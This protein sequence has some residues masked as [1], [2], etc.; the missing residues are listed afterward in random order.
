MS[1]VS[2]EAAAA[3][4]KAEEVAA[5]GEKDAT[6]SPKQTVGVKAPEV[7]G[8]AVPAVVVEGKCDPPP[9]AEEKP[10]EVPQPKKA[11]AKKPMGSVGAPKKSAPPAGMSAAKS[12]FESGG[13]A[14]STG[15]K[16]SWKKGASAGAAAIKDQMLAWCQQRTRGYS[17]VEVNNFS[18]SWANG[19]AFCALI[20]SFV[21]D[22]FD[23]DSLNPKERRKNFDLAFKVADEAMGAAPL[24]DTDD[25]IAMGGKPDWKCVFTY[26]Q[27]L[28]RH[29]TIFEKSGGKAPST[30]TT[31]T[32]PT[33]EA[34]QKQDAKEE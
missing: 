29:G 26:V 7:A 31:P 10:K 11:P 24:L 28:Y 33:M 20:H 34:I 13:G 9:A 18:S 6:V 3:E 19:M 27:S 2:G 25:M 16:P 14:A 30:P 5:A 15:A 12:K 22:K 23:F 21:P 4:G 1:E 32:S 17:N 8:V